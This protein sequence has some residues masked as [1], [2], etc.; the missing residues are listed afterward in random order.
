M[1]FFDKISLNKK[2]SAISLERNKKTW[3][4][5]ET[6]HPLW[7]MV[8]PYLGLI[9]QGIADDSNCK[10]VFNVFVKADEKSLNQVSK[11]LVFWFFWSLDRHAGYN[12]MLQDAKTKEY[13]LKIWNLNSEEF[14]K[15]IHLFDNAKGPGGSSLLLLKLICEKLNAENLATIF[16]LRHVGIIIVSAQE[17]VLKPGMLKKLHGV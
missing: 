8:A 13:F 3:E 2:I 14:E 10:E 15:L 12:D 17:V 6:I 5:K 9:F 11:L 7:I 16:T 1:K 4:L